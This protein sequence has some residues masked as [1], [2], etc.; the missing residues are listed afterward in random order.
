MLAGARSCVRLSPALDPNRRRLPSL[1]CHHG[2]ASR[3]QALAS[4]VALREEVASAEAALAAARAAR[5]S[6]SEERLEVLAQ[7]RASLEVRMQSLQGHLDEEAENLDTLAAAHEEV[8]ALSETLRAEKGDLERR[9]ACSEEECGSAR[10]ELQAAIAEARERIAQAKG[11][12]RAEAP[13]RSLRETRNPRGQFVALPMGPSESGSKIMRGPAGGAQQVQVTCAYVAGEKSSPGSSER[14]LASVLFE[15]WKLC[16]VSADLWR[17]QV[18]RLQA[19]LQSSSAKAQEVLEALRAEQEAKG[20]LERRLSDER[21]EASWGAQPCARDLAAVGL[22]FR[23]RIGCRRRIGGGEGGYWSQSPGEVERREAQRRDAA[24]SAAATERLHEAEARRAEVEQ[25][26][27]PCFVKGKGGAVHQG[28]CTGGGALARASA[29]TRSAPAA[30]LFVPCAP[31]LLRPRARP[32]VRQERRAL[33][34]KAA[35]APTRTPDSSPPAPPAQA[36]APSP[37]PLSS[38]EGFDPRPGREGGICRAFALAPQVWPE[39]GS[40]RSGHHHSGFECTALPCMRR[41]RGAKPMA[42]RM[43]HCG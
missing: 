39:P 29:Y 13:P 9:L 5:Q 6:A 27:V 24:A 11:E 26:R 8:L 4:E 17:P 42:G 19:Q 43:K 28:R 35:E 3:A 34:C 1:S 20:G 25:E 41:Q 30:S 2:L 7:E 18:E 38:V 10:G 33:E 21:A 22:P 31:L 16:L 23:G 36:A 12:Q 37:G 40:R 14:H 15:G 32:P